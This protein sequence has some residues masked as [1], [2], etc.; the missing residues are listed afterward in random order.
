MLID[1]VQSSS[2]EIL[3]EV[4]AQ[5]HLMAWGARLG[6]RSTAAGMRSRSGLCPSIGGACVAHWRHR[7]ALYFTKSSFPRLSPVFPKCFRGCWL[8]CHGAM[9][10][11]SCGKDKGRPSTGHS[12]TTGRAALS[13]IPS[14]QEC[15]ACRK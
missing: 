13:A 5:C 4:A 6:T 15:L 1:H 10:A 9:Q 11:V 14:K 3:R 7:T 8:I 12:R 2:L